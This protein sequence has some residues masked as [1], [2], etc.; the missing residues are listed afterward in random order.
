[1]RLVAAV[2]FQELEL[3]VFLD[4]LGDDFQLQ[5]V[6]ERDDAKSSTEGMNVEG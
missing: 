3:R 1:L 5:A 4:A 2:G 6:A